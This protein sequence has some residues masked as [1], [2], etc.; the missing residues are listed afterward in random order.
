MTG[1]LRSKTNASIFISALYF[2][3]W[4]IIVVLFPSILSSVVIDSGKTPVIFWDFMSVITFVLGIGMM[5]AAANPYKHWAIIL[6]VSL[7]HIGIIGGFIFGYSIGFFNNLFI[8]FI[9]FNHFIWLIPNA[10]VLYKVY[11]RSFDTDKMMM[12]TFNNDDYPLSMFDTID[13]RNLGEMNENNQVM[14]VFLRHFGCPFCKESLI[15]LA[16]HRKELES[17]GISIVL[18]YMIEPEAANAYLNEYGLADLAQ[19]SDPEEIFYKSFRLR[20]G[21]FVQLFGLK[22]WLRWIE[23]GFK[24]K[25]FN[26]SPA[27]NVA[28]M[29]GIFL[30]EEGKVIKQYVHKSIADAPDYRFF[31]E[32]GDNTSYN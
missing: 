14:L 8:R 15:E 11:R 12:E 28:Q 18:V 21:S 25:L 4:S 16:A 20:R 22:V 2:I 6:I 7:F 32:P 3:I 26:T 27:G 5:I 23:L 13:G 1:L 24:K 17:R 10:I 19:V 9:L 29:P 30:V 31:L